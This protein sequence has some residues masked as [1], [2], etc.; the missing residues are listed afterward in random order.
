MDHHAKILPEE[1]VRPA[2]ERDLD[3]MS[4]RTNNNVNMFWT[5]VVPVP[6]FGEFH[7][8]QVLVCRIAGSL[9][10]LGLLFRSF[11]MLCSYCLG[12]EVAGRLEYRGY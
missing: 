1:E 5:N 4:R 11:S 7:E 12:V 8:G 3:F 2:A 6:Q 9:E 10:E